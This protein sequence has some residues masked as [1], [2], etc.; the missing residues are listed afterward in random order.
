[1]K[2]ET[3]YSKTLRSKPTEEELTMS[4]LWPEVE[5]VYGHGYEVSKAELELS[6]T[7]THKPFDRCLHG[8]AVC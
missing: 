5:K 3:L 6:Y 4:T 7:V 1:M 8:V 2:P